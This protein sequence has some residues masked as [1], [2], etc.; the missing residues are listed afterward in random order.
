MFPSPPPQ[1]FVG[2]SVKLEYPFQ[3]QYYVT[4][5]QFGQVLQMLVA[6]VTDIINFL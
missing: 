2:L 5:R 3:N 1:V 4:I 6:Y